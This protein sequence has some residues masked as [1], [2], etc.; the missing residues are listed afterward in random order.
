MWSR[1]SSNLNLVKFDPDFIE[2]YRSRSIRLG[3]F[4]LYE[5]RNSSPLRHSS[6][7]FLA[8]ISEDDIII[9][10]G[11]MNP[12]FQV[13]KKSLLEVPCNLLCN[14]PEEENRY[15]IPFYDYLKFCLN[16]TKI[17]GGRFDLIETF[18]EFRDLCAFH[19]I[20]SQA[21]DTKSLIPPKTLRK[22]IYSCFPTVAQ[23]S[24]CKI[25]DSEVAEGYSF[26]GITF[27]YKNSLYKASIDI[28]T[29][30]NENEYGSLCFRDEHRLH[31]YLDNSSQTYSA[32]FIPCGID[33]LIL[34]NQ[35]EMQYIGT[36]IP[37]YSNT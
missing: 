6:I 30:Q 12:V 29:N 27:L 9:L 19:M 37:K 13:W 2:V 18:D 23:P 34:D 17:N 28:Y 5:I 36:E 33:A 16:N 31:F 14:R 24:I 21:T 20:G 15:G 22:I 11:T 3:K 10:D 8:D 35:P 26:E 32:L 1:V 7:R 4:R 25:I